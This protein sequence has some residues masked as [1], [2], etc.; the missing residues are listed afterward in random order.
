MSSV[1]SGSLEVVYWHTTGT[2]S[3]SLNL[4]NDVKALWSKALELL[5]PTVPPEYTTQIETYLK[6]AN[7]T[8]CAVQDF[9][10]NAS[11]SS[12]ARRLDLEAWMLTNTSQLEDDIRVFLPE[13]YPPE[14]HD[15]AEAFL[16]TTYCELKSSSATIS[17]ANGTADFNEIWM[18]EGDFKAQVNHVKTFYADLMNATNP[19]MP[20]WMYDLI[21][22]TEIDID[23]L[24]VK[25]KLG[26]DSMYFSF[27]GLCF[28]PQR[29]SIDHVRFRLHDFFNFTYSPS[30][31]PQTYQR[32]RLAVRGGA[33]ATHMVLL[34]APDTMLTPSA[35][36]LN[37]TTM[38]W[39]N[40]TLSSLRSLHFLVAFQGVAEHAGT[41]YYVPIFS[42]STV[43]AFS[44]SRNAKKIGFNVAGTEGTGSCN[45]TIP[46]ALL[47]ANAQEWIITVD[48]HQLTLGE[49]NVTENAEYAFIYFEYS[50][51]IHLI[52]VTGTWVVPE[53]PPNVLPLVLAIACLVVAAVAVIKRRRIYA[54]KAQT[55]MAISVFAARLHQTKA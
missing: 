40:N 41:N 26:E 44:F 34:Y 36:A 13:M 43:S 53:F 9:S 48:G 49:F 14:L 46:K 31:P 18:L 2:G 32:M 29:N 12:S 7:A 35:V 24:A 52:E 4:R 25:A 19:Y 51:S 21:N 1:Q 38:N 17:Y 33:N 11:Y 30:E 27:D 55:R 45:L 39:Q 10:L 42:N 54:L 50:H 22:D 23:N 28:K 16:N 20:E 47:Y 15:I 8:A 37:Y 3:V 6:M 5:P